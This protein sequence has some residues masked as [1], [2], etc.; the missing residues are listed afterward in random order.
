MLCSQSSKKLLLTSTWRTPKARHL[1]IDSRT[2]GWSKSCTSLWF[3]SPAQ[4]DRKIDGS[5]HSL[6]TTNKARPWGK[7][8]VGIGCGTWIHVSLS[9]LING[10]STAKTQM[11]LQGT[12]HTS[13]HGDFL[14]EIARSHSISLM[15]PLSFFHQFFKPLYLISNLFYFC[16]FGSI[17]NSSN[18]DTVCIFGSVCSVNEKVCSFGCDHHCVIDV[19]LNHIQS[20]FILKFMSCGSHLVMYWYLSKGSIRLFVLCGCHNHLFEEFRLEGDF[21]SQWVSLVCLFEIVVMFVTGYIC[22]IDRLDEWFRVNSWL[23]GAFLDG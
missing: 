11:L 5:S 12:S 15:F 19:L 9:Y 23:F 13:P 16:K 17:I 7:P 14:F 21:H 6:L 2:A 8:A 22:T 18:E 4:T 10:S 20:L 1:N 3:V